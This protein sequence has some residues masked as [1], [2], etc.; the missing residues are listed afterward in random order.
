M[1]TWVNRARTLIAVAVV[2]AVG[3]APA[4]A[5]D[6]SAGTPGFCS[7][8][9]TTVVVDLSN[10][11]GD[12]IVRCAPGS[13]KRTGF[14]TLED[15]GFEYETTT[16]SGMTSVCRL[17][18]RPAA[19]EELDIDGESGY[20]ETC[21]GMP[22][23]AA[24]WSY[25]KADDGGEWGFSQKG[26]QAQQENADFQAWTFAL[27][28]TPEEPVTP[29]LDPVRPS[30]DPGDSGTQDGVEWTGGQESSQD[31]ESASD[32]SGSNVAPWVAGG[33]IAALAVLIALT[34][35]R[36]RAR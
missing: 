5:V 34:V 19:D 4:V 27:N 10:L 13:E 31:A 24:Y 17:E 7:D 33:V 8:D 6:D 11:G 22:P 29:V 9:G 3:G 1:G 25:W 26:P 15:A 30:G 2:A 23:A 21:S 32:D 28:S 16:G 14:Q 12:V 20:Q 18:G 36:R 35:V